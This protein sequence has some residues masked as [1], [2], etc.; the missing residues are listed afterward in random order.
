MNN[1]KAQIDSTTSWC[2]GIH[3]KANK[4][5]LTVFPME[6]YRPIDLYHNVGACGSCVFYVC[7]CVQCACAVSILLSEWMSVNVYSVHTCIWIILK[8]ELCPVHVFNFKHN[9]KTHFK[10]K[11]THP[12]IH[13]SKRMHS[14]NYILV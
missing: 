13:S 1:A 11:S 9:I 2:I 14:N 8:V 3:I 10:F 4:A 12:S 7:L 6:F 5:R